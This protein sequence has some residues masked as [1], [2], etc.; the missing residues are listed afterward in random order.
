MENKNIIIIAVLAIVLV[1]GVIFATSIITPSNNTNNTNNTNDTINVTI[2]DTNETN[3]T[4][5]TTSTNTKEASSSK[6]S[7]KSDSNI[8]DESIKEN[9][10][11]GDGSHYREVKYKDGNIRQYDTSGKLIGSSYESDQAQLKRDAGASW[12]GD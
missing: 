8:V 2:N 4:T 3:N 12:P 7:S 6:K 1:L 9:Y 5:N 10:Q 11:A